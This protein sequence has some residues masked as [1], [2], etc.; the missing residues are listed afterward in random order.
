LMVCTGCGAVAEVSDPAMTRQ[1][2][3]RVSRTGFALATQ[4]IEI[5]ALCPA[6]QKKRRLEE[7]HDGGIT[8]EHRHDG[9]G[10]SHTH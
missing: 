9:H 4:E 7:K 6:C 5:R 10:S 8:H 3:E 2:A 1:L